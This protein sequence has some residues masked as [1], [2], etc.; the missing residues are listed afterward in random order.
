MKPF[1]GSVA[2]RLLVSFSGLRG[3]ASIVFAILAVES[4]VVMENDLFHIAFVVVL[5]SIALQ[6]SLLPAVARKLGMIDEEGN[7]LRTFTDYVDETPVNF[8]QLEIEAG[9]SWCGRKISE[10]ELPP[11]TLLV[12]LRRGKTQ[13]V[14]KGDTCLQA[15]DLL[16]MCALERREGTDFCLT[17][18]TVEADELTPGATLADLPDRP[19]S[20]IVLIRRGHECLLPDG[21]T[22]LQPGDH[23]LINH[24]EETAPAR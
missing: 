18:R 14:P 2:R 4:P 17:E 22:R 20:L 19:G 21:N 23:L 15:G 16:V 6:G 13:M 24:V 3:A 5:F 8:V 10:L 7:V 11:G 12:S 1:G 9:H